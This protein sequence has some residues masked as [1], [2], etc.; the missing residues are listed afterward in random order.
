MC[1]IGISTCLINKTQLLKNKYKSKL[2]NPA[3]VVNACSPRTQEVD[4]KVILN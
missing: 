1:V 3:V 4:W 2:H